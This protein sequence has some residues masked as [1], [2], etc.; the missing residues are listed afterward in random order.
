MQWV[1][2]KEWNKQFFASF[3]AHSLSG[4]EFYIKIRMLE[5]YDGFYTDNKGIDV[6]WFRQYRT[7]QY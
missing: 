1:R 3:A 6:S 2:L 4:I 7:V 5:N